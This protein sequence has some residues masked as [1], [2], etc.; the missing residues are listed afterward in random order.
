M[1]S[2]LFIRQHRL[3]D[4]RTL[5][6]KADK[7][8][9]V[10]M[11]FAL[12]QIQG[13]QLARCKLP[14]WAAED[15]V[16]F[17]PHLSMEQCSSEQAARYKCSVVERLLTAEERQKGMMTDL[18]GGFG[19]DFSYMARSFERRYM[20]SNKN[21]SARLHAT[22]STASDCSRPRWCMETGSIFC[23]VYKTS[24]R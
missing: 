13:W 18:T 8:P 11:P 19:V 4:V 24:R 15:G 3:D 10:D 23:I 9:E 6:F 12:E 16:L 17:P 14:E 2:E 5:A 7:Y 22:I 21:D 20:W 1:N